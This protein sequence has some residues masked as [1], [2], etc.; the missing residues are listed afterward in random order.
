MNQPRHLTRRRRGHHTRSRDEQ[1]C[2]DAFAAFL[3]FDAPGAG[4]SLSRLG[5][6]VLAGKVRP[7]ARALASAVD[8]VLG[9][10]GASGRDVLFDFTVSPACLLG[11]CRS[12]ERGCQSALCE[13]D[14][15]VGERAAE[16]GRLG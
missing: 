8:A 15:H 14:C 4:R 12:G 10:D 13:H 5:V 1:V 7:A 3:R 9:D 6:G 2:L 11:Q 16:L